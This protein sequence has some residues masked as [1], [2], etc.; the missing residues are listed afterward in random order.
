MGGGLA[1][2]AASLHL[3]RAGLKVV[4]IEPAEAIRQPVGESLD[5]SAPHL[6][7]ALGLPMDDLIVAQM[8]TWKRQVTLKSRD[9]SAAHDV[10]TA[11]LG[12][13][14][15]HI[16]LRTLHGD[17][18]HPDQR[19]RKMTF[20]GGV[21]LIQNK[22]AGIERDGKNISAVH[23]ASGARFSSPWFIDAS[24]F[25]TSLLGREFNLPAIPFGPA[26]VAFWTY[27]AVPE[28]TDGSVHGNHA[29]R[30]SRLG[31]GDTPEWLGQTG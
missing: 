18:L 14:P 19:L 21:T 27:F 15:F 4:R 28:S 7:S 24:G 30:V 1:E 31:L 17:R 11:W 22:V 23:A 8:A 16:E 6:L 25:A 13:A 3:A 26:K 29:E 2:K 10:P 20:E 9:G 12:G 5:W